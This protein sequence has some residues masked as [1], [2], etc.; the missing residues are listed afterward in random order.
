MDSSTLDIE[1][2][3]TLDARANELSKSLSQVVH[4]LQ[5]EMKQVTLKFAHSSSDSN[6]F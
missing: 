4:R 2:F 3:R 6:D 5:L 1:L